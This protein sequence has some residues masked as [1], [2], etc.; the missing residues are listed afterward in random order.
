M[1]ANAGVLLLPNTGSSRDLLRQSL[2]ENWK[3][4]DVFLDQTALIRTTHQLKCDWLLQL[5][6]QQR[7]GSTHQNDGHDDDGEARLLQSRVRGT[8]IGLFRSG[9]WILHLPNHNRYQMALSIHDAFRK[10]S[11]FQK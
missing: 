11:D 8:N 2:H 9:D 6:Q 4:E 3:R 10:K 5:Q 7:N 1:S